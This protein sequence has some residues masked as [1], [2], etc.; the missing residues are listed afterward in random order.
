MYTHMHIEGAC[1]PP[2]SRSPCGC[3]PGRPSGSPAAPDFAN[4]DFAPVD[5]H[6]YR[7]IY[8]YRERERE[9]YHLRLD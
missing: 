2:S 6:M 9:L 7:Y 8:I 3:S 4:A 5:T 1:Q